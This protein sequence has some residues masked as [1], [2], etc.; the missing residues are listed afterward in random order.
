[1]LR[2]KYFEMNCVI[3]LTEMFEKLYE[4]TQVYDKY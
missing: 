4:D 1:M 2:G 3:G